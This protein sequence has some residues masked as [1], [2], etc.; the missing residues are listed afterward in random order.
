MV[1]FNLADVIGLTY[2]WSAAISIKLLN[3]VYEN[4]FQ[5]SKLGEYDRIFVLISTTFFLNNIINIRPL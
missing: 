4:I 2:D 1:L 5:K 3:K